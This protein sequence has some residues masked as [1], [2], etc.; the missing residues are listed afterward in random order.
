MIEKKENLMTEEQ[1]R[2]FSTSGVIP[3]PVM[4][5][6]VEAEETTVE[7]S[8][9]IDFCSFKLIQHRDS[10]VSKL[11]SESLIAIQKKG[12]DEPDTSIRPAYVLVREESGGDRPT[13][14]VKKLFADGP[15]FQLF[16]LQWPIDLM[17]QIMLENCREKIENLEMESENFKEEIK[18]NTSGVSELTG[19]VQ[20]F[21]TAVDSLNER[22]LKLDSKMAVVATKEELSVLATRVNQIESRL[23]K[24]MDE[25]LKKVVDRLDTQSND[26][27]YILDFLQEIGRKS[28]EI[29]GRVSYQT[30]V[31]ANLLNDSHEKFNRFDSRIKT[32][33]EVIG[34]LNKRIEALEKR[35]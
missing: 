35:S 15:R 19:L 20:N 5:I 17:Q 16:V 31:I 18:S 28:A 4:L 8:V 7:L 13:I 10:G 33:A 11:L 6:D 12:D 1:L 25:K 26:I 21:K 22:T 23:S 9:G 32:V 24:S 3:K 34:A 29:E 14:S 27:D 30:G 2:L